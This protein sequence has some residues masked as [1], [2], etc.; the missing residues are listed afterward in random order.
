MKKK[1]QKK[2]IKHNIFNLRDIIVLIC[3]ILDSFILELTIDNFS[4]NRLLHS[5]IRKIR[6]KQND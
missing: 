5:Y 4:N 1:T 3:I 2:P 6:N